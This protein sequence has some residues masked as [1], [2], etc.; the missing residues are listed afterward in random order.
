VAG[1]KADKTMK[2]LAAEFGINRLTESAYVHRADVPIRRA[3]LGLQLAVE[4]VSLY[5]AG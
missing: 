5:Q 3:G 2:G 1:Y 4:V